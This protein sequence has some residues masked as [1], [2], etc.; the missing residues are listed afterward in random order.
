MW[1]KFRVVE[2]IEYIDQEPRILLTKWILTE[3]TDDGGENKVNA[4]LVV[5]ENMEDGL[6]SIQTQ[7]PTCGKDTV[8]LL[9]TVAATYG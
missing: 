7:S 1:E 5:L 4:R 8:R 2:N 9:L 3:K 6:A